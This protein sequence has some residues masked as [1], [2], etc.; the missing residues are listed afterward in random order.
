[1]EEGF[2][3]GLHDAAAGIQG[4]ALPC[5]LI[6]EDKTADACTG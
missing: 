5:G 6:F 1:M 2:A 3:S 4:T